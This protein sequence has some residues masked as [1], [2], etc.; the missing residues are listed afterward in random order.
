MTCIVGFIENGNVW[1]GGDS[2]GI[3]GLSCITREDQKVFRN[4]EMIFGFTSSFR[5][6]QVLRY[7]F[8]Q[9]EQSQFK[10]DYEYM[11]TDFIDSVGTVLADA[12]FAAIENNVISIGSFLVGYNGKLYHVE[13][14][15]QVAI[16]SRNYNACGAGEDI[17][18]G[19]LYALENIKMSPTERITK[20]LEAASEYCA[21]V[22]GPYIIKSLYLHEEPK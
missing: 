13:D 6:G 12:N 7:K 20:A 19:A 5:M 16:S 14:D 18:L 21:A 3:G 22:R 9:P 1:I 8:N 2:L 15:L 17:A 11:V 10:S 4:G